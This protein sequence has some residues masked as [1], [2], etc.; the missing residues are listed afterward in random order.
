[1]SQ[2]TA[3]PIGHPITDQTL[4]ATPQ[5]ILFFNSLFV[6]DTGTVWTP[7]F[8]NLTQVGGDATITGKYFKISQSLVYFRIDI[9][10][11]TNTSSVAGTTYCDNFPLSMSGDGFNV[12]VAPSSGTGGAIGVNTASSGRIFTPNW[13]NVTV[14]VIILGMVEAQ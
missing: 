1:M 11:A 5:W 4:T 6:G 3:P 2:I 8:Q 12:S 13:T 14:P 7:T 9:T 10:P